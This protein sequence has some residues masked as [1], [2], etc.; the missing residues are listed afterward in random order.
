MS[1]LTLNSPS[2]F[3]VSV[4]A[5]RTKYSSARNVPSCSVP[6]LLRRSV[7]PPPHIPF[8]FFPLADCIASDRGCRG[9]MSGRIGIRTILN[10]SVGH[11][12]NILKPTKPAL[13]G[14]IQQEKTSKSICWKYSVDCRYFSSCFI[15]H[16]VNGG[17]IWDW[18][19]HHPS[20]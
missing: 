15:F 1:R 9:R 17:S 10:L 19:G 4:C 6:L 7:F 18:M 8:F 13:E 3:T 11:F 12:L 16:S 2:T 14:L 20:R 5:S